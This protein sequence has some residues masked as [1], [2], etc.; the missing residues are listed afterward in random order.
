[1]YDRRERSSGR[2]WIPEWEDWGVG[3]HLYWYPGRLSTAGLDGDSAKEDI[4][5]V[6]GKGGG[7]LRVKRSV[8]RSPLL[9]LLYSIHFIVPYFSLWC[10]RV[11]QSSPGHL[12]TTFR[13]E[14]K[15]WLTLC[16]A[17]TGA[18]DVPKFRKQAS[19][20]TSRQAVSHQ[21]QCP[22]TYY[23]LHRTVNED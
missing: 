1:M 7:G 11:R 23:H 10:N 20:R 22:A 6:E 9:Y 4:D 8:G 21:N 3:G 17:R 5:L 14:S 18:Y 13:V 2:V 12:V 16:G 19:L 15:M